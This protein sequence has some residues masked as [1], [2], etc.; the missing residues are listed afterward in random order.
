MLDQEMVGQL[1]TWLLTDFLG[2][3]PG[4]L[5]IEKPHQKSQGQLQGGRLP[6]LLQVHGRRK[7]EKGQP[8]LREGGEVLGFVGSHVF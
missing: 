4:S 3:D 8:L 1:V 2:G 6:R 7:E 5:G